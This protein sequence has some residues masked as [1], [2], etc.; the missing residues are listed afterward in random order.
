V[1]LS[2]PARRLSRRAR[3]RRRWATIALFLAPALALYLLLVV[4]PVVQA[5]YYSGFRW[6]GLGSLDDFVGLENFKRAF[7]DDVFLGALKHNA[8]IVVL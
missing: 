1:V 2:A 3:A 4:A 8:I 6:S 5:I 7:S